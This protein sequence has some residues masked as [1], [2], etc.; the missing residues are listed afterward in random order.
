M[1]QEDLA[2]D[3]EAQDWEINNR[4]RPAPVEFKPGD[5]GY[6]PAFCTGREKP[7][8]EDVEQE[9]LCGEEMPPLRRAMG[10]HLCVGCQTLLERGRLR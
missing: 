2:Q 5:K 6:G 4:P 9:D 1:S 3:R 7:P 10:K 8:V